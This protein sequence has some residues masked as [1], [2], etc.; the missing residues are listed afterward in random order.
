S[1]Q[2][3]GDQTIGTAWQVVSWTIKA[4]SPQTRILFD[5]GQAA[6]TYYIDDV[7]I[8]EVIPAP[9]GAQI[10]NKLDTALNT[11][12]TGMVTRYKD[13]VRAWDVVNE[14][15]TDDGS[16]RNNTNTPPPAGSSDHFV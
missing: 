6:N 16:I 15:F 12:I 2:Y 4:N 5:M 10:V 7:I 13:K 3:Q 14:L 9:S 11:F 1:A 8:K